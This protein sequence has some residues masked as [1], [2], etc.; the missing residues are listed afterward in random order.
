MRV[1]VANSS[2]IQQGNASHADAFEALMAAAEAGDYTDNDD[3]TS[4]M[5]KAAVEPLDIDF[6]TRMLRREIK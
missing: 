6:Q 3:G 1:V 2:S 5:V 4:A